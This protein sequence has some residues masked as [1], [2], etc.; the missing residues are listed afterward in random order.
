M[1]A[2]YHS[3]SVLVPASAVAFEAEKCWQLQGEDVV[4]VVP[5]GGGQ[6]GQGVVAPMQHKSNKGKVRVY[7]SG[8][9]LHFIIPQANGSK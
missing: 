1:T 8:R 9:R 6:D 7:S 2:Q 3:G 4:A 5:L